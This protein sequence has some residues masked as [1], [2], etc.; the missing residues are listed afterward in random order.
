[1]TEAIMHDH[2]SE[3]TDG[4]LLEEFSDIGGGVFQSDNVAGGSHVL[5]AHGFADIEN[6][7]NM[8]DDSSLKGLG[9]LSKS[10]TMVSLRLWRRHRR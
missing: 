2:D 5:F 4:V 3:L 1:M 6:E 8:S 9:I 10:G 7:D